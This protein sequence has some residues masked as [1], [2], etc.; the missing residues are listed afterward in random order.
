MA[1]PAPTVLGRKP[2]SIVDSY[3]VSLYP[4]CVRS[5]QTVLLSRFWSRCASARRPR[6][7]GPLMY[8]LQA[9]DILDLAHQPSSLGSPL[10][11][12]HSRHIAYGY[13]IP[14][15]GFW[16]RLKEVRQFNELLGTTGG[17]GGTAQAL[18]LHEPTGRR[19]FQSGTLL[20]GPVLSPGILLALWCFS[21]D[22]FL[23]STVRRLDTESSRSLSCILLST[24]A[25]FDPADSR[26]PNP[27]SPLKCD[28]S[29]STGTGS[30]TTATDDGGN[31]TDLNSFLVPSSGPPPF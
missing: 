19:N 1:L 16:H 11:I 18:G 22:V 23:F 28:M 15:Q 13:A 14:T 27:A 31:G 29:L 7:S 30:Y 25:P 8:S 21:C 26:S 9:I 4:D 5:T 20:P 6:A 17:E 3:E 12:R 24:P 2:V 10:F